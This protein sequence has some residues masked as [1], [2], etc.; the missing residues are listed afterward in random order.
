MNN[1]PRGPL[2]ILG[3]DGGI[4][5]IGAE[6]VARPNGIT[7]ADGIDHST[8]QFQ[9]TRNGNPISGATDATY[10]V[11][12]ADTGADIGLRGSYIDGDDNQETVIAKPIKVPDPFRD[13]LDST[14]QILFE[15]DA[16]PVGVRLYGGARRNGYSLGQIATLLE[17]DKARGAK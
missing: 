4:A 6:L 17:A 2:G 5:Q 10:R 7:D 9:W 11:T 12:Q 15:R 16:D 1:A 3:D 14:Y 13:W 8:W